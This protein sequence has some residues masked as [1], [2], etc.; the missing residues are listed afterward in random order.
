MNI[1]SQTIYDW[2]HRNKRELPWRNST[3]AYR[4]WISEIMLQ[5]TRVA[6]TVFYFNRFIEI[7]PTVFDLAKAKEDTVLKLWQG[8]GYYT[9]AR[10]LHKA[11]KI[12]VIEYDGDFPSEYTEILRLPGIGK[13]TAAAIASIAYHQPFA[14]VDGNVYRIL[15]RYFG[16]QTPIDSE[17]G[18]NEFQHLASAL[19]KDANPGLHNQA[20]MD[21]G[22]LQCTP[23]SPDC[24]N[25]VLN[26]SCFAAKNRMV[27]SLPVKRKKVKT[28]IRYF[29]YY[30]ISSGDF[31]LFQKRTAKDIWQ[32]LYQF[33]LI[34]TEKEIS[35][36]E[37]LATEIPWIAGFVYNVKK[38]SAT[39]KHQLTHQTIFARFI[40][41]ESTT[42]PL[43]DSDFFKAHKK[44]IFTFAVP[45][46][47]E[48]VVKKIGNT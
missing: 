5:Q 2:Y 26:S 23:K 47:L 16:I 37:I 20:I 1:F 35:D 40:F 22:A 17:K 31:F 10:N 19:L 38:I 9:R 21:F 45:R 24:F 3:D 7:F 30:I 27:S 14:V 41:V 46:L 11:A 29:Y 33:P 39:Y 13:Y 12:I 48:P 43:C 44:D 34:E 6:Q 42:L 28:T 18:K 8:L 4:I 36:S 25:C 15:S 32:N